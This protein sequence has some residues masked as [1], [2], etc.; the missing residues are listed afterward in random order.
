MSDVTAYKYEVIQRQRIIRD[1]YIHKLVHLL[2]K[3]LPNSL[4]EYY[5]SPGRLAVV[6]RRFENA[7][8]RP[9][10]DPATFAMELG[11]LAVR[12]FED[13]GER[14]CDLMIRNKFI[15]AQQSCELRRH[16]DGAAAEASIRDIV[17]S[18]RV[19]ESHSEAGYSGNGGPN[20]KFL[21]TISQVAED[22]QPQMVTL[23]KNMRQLLLTPALSPPRVG[24]CTSRPVSDT[25][26]VARNG[27]W[28]YDSRVTG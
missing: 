24:G 16:L 11:T 12:G 23:H 4:S 20:P 25:E 17:D 5:N 14:A 2:Q 26:A 7:S 13:M 1:I 21:Q 27:Y 15:A 18:F 8:H 9:G 6:R 28:T 22:T 10:V 3:D 19:R